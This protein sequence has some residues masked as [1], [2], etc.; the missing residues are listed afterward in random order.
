[1][2]F[3]GRG[4]SPI[5]R[6]SSSN[7]FGY[8]RFIRRT[9]Y[10]RYYYYDSKLI[11]LSF[12]ASIFVLLIVALSYIFIYKPS[13]LDPIESLK[14]S[15]IKWHLFSIL[16]SSFLLGLSILFSKSKETLI[17]TLKLTLSL[18]IIILFILIGIKLN[19][20]KTYDEEKFSQFYESE[21]LAEPSIV[22]Q[23]FKV[24]LSGIKLL[25]EREIY[26]DESVNAYN[27]FTVKTILCN[28]LYLAII[29]FTIYL[30]T[31]V[32]K[33]KEKSDHISKDDKILFDEEQNVKF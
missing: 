8:R 20:N 4:S 28:T 27:C 15:Y 26:I 9:P 7:G 6:S 17:K 5:P 2:A 32:T 25:G 12:L 1:M 3:M 22:N 16:F 18:S 10:I 19:Y 29:L 11:I 14:N 21:N 13:F 24:N 23:K 33:S 30:L 31:K